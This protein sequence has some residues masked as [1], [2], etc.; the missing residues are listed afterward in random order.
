MKTDSILLEL[1]AVKENFA[2]QANGDT[3]RFLDQMETWA[4]VHPHA[5]PVVNSPEEL[6]ARLRTRATEPLP[7]KGKPYRVHDPIIAEVRRNRET[8]YFEQQTE[9]FV[10]KDEPPKKNPAR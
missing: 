3:R 2:V 4:V 9:A 5:G 6:Q 7:S 8:L 10:L 1:K